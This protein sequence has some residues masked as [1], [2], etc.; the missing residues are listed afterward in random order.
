PPTAGL[1]SGDVGAGNKGNSPSGAAYS[2]VSREQKLTIVGVSDLDPE[3]MRG[4]M[5]AKVFLPLKFGENLHVMQPTDL[6]EVARPATDQPVY[7]SI[8]VRARNATQL[9]ALED[10]LK[11]MGFPTFSILDATR[12]MRQ[13]LA[14]LDLFL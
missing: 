2:V 3:S 7:S 11:K 10:A 1:A 5:R 9:Q 6:R 13:F 12:S 4:P 8:S 14:V